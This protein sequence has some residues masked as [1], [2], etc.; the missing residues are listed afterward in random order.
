MRPLYN[1]KI[2]RFINTDML[3]M[4]VKALSEIEIIYQIYSDLIY[5]TK[6][7]VI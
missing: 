6:N 2:F 1:F 7:A 5:E 4:D 3:N